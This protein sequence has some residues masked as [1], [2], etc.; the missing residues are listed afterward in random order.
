MNAAEHL[1]IGNDVILTGSNNKPL[2]VP[3]L[4]TQNGLQLTYGQ[5]NA[6]GDFFG[7][8]GT[9]ISTAA[10]PVQAFI[11][12]FNTMTTPSA[13]YTVQSI[14][15]ILDTEVQ[16]LAQGQTN[17]VAPNIVYSNLG[18]SLSY[19]WALVTGPVVDDG[20]CSAWSLPFFSQL[21]T[22]AAAT[23]PALLL[24]NWDHFGAEALIVYKAGHQ[25]A[26]TVALNAYAAAAAGN[27]ISAS[28]LLQQAYAMNAFADHFLVDLFASGHLRTP[29]LTM[30]TY[31]TAYWMSSIVA[32]ELDCHIVA[33][34]L[35]M[36]MHNEDSATG[37]SVTNSM[38]T[39]W[40][41]YGDSFYF[42]PQ[43]STSANITKQAV[44]AS[45][46]EVFTV[47]T[48][49][50]TVSSADFVALQ[51]T[52]TVASTGN[53][54]PMFIYSNGGIELRSPVTNLSS[55][56]WTAAWKPYAALA[57]VSGWWP[58]WAPQID[59]AM[60]SSP[61][62]TAG[63]FTPADVSV[64][65]P[66]FSFDRKLAG[67]STQGP[68]LA[69]YN[70]VLYC[71]YKGS[72][73]DNG[74][75]DPTIYYTYSSDGITWS[76]P[77]TLHQSGNVSETSASPA[78]AVYTASNGTAQLYCV[79]KDSSGSN[80]WYTSYNSTTQQWVADQKFNQ[81]PTY[82]TNS[83][84]TS[85]GP[86][87]AAYTTPGGSALLVCVYKSNSGDDIYYTSF[88]GTA[89]SADQK[90]NLPA[91]YKTNSSLTDNSPAL[92]TYTTGGVTN[93]YC[94]YKDDSSDNLWCTV[95]DGSGWS[96]DIQFSASETNAGPA[97]VVYGGVLYCVFKDNS[98]DNLRYT[99]NAG[100]GWGVGL[101]TDFVFPTSLTQTDPSVAVMDG[102]MFCAY[103]DNSGWQLWI[104]VNPTAPVL[105]T[106]LDQG[107]YVTATFAS[108][109]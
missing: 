41:A 102:V 43:N 7:V 54:T 72:Q 8:V 16:A 74:G 75:D 94:V 2:S 80:L 78:L 17:N 37:L 4:L 48:T 22:A 65:G 59:E 31:L 11:N 93:L 56:T 9:P 86:A 44:Q 107:G 109:T 85:T 52:P 32:Q 63:T 87:L 91:T 10:D 6:L 51:F 70:G 98:S 60:T 45:A 105:I 96:P 77:Q 39:I 38:G 47:F 40:T 49:G 99:I 95:Y 35:S 71:V 61:G 88:D 21:S 103:L 26:L 97:L 92:A 18:N 104:C 55:T 14:L 57:Q 12:A 106:T 101:A 76:A 53:T 73:S 33:A 5:L 46:T 36:Y 100:L 25:A 90:L 13:F 15:A 19:E 82:K 83:S 24:E 3:L 66:A 29:R 89:W 68:A 79:Y 27:S 42:T 50:K 67:T 108:S 84:L 64:L 62:G 58:T 23:Y 20:Y 69:T 28:Q 30:D 81:P 34:A 1:A